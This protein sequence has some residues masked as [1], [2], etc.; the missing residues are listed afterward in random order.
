[1]TRVE[2]DTNLSTR[3]CRKCSIFYNDEQ[4]LH[5]EQVEF[6]DRTFYVTR[7]EPC[8]TIL[9]DSIKIGTGNPL[10]IVSLL[11]SVNGKKN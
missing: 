10:C 11:D 1:M 8:E 7:V 5:R 4:Y 2:I 6:K 9:E 3:C